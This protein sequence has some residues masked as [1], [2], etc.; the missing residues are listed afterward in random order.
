MV[1]ALVCIGIGVAYAYCVWDLGREWP[2]VGRR[3]RV[4]PSR[5]IG[6]VTDNQGVD[7]RPSTTAL[8]TVR[9]RRAAGAACDGRITHQS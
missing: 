6:G 1:T 8:L 2:D 5:R 9:R 7:P 3:A 4:D